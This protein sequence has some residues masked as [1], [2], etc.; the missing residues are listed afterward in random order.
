[1]VQSTVTMLQRCGILILIAADS[2]TLAFVPTTTM[3]ALPILLLL[4]QRQQRVSSA[5]GTAAQR[6][7]PH[8]MAPQYVNDEWRYES[9]A[10]RPAA[11]YGVLGTLL[12]H[13]PKPAA[14]RV[15]QAAA[16]EQAVLKFMAGDRCDRETAQ[17]NMDAYLR[18]PQDWTYARMEDVKN[19]YE[20]QRDYVTIAPLQIAS[21]LVWTAVVTFCVARGLYCL[22]TGDYFVCTWTVPTPI[23]GRRAVAAC[24]TVARSQ[25][26]LFVVRLVWY[27]IL[28]PPQPRTV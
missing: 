22:A 16:Y 1:M 21:V 6:R 4:R 9:D 24:G 10:E 8:R 23:G 17:G 7:L 18:N 28:P 5:D 27:R 11:G 26:A 14:T 19:G 2:M 25:A 13:G 20:R 12:R 3:T 15:L